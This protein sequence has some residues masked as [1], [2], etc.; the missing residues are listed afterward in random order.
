VVFDFRP[1]KSTDGQA[2]SLAG[3]AS[4]HVQVALREAWM[5]KMMGLVKSFWSCSVSLA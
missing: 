1:G 5:M 2:I 4:L 3:R